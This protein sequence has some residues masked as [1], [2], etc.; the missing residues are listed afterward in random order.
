MIPYKVVNV[1]STQP[2]KQTVSVPVFATPSTYSLVQETGSGLPVIP[3]L[4]GAVMVIA[5]IVSW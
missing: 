4:A 2:A 5:A 1:F 3:L